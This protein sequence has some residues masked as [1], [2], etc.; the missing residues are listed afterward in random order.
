MNIPFY[1]S[2]KRSF[3]I[4]ESPRDFSRVRPNLSPYRFFLFVVERI[5]G[6]REGRTTVIKDA[7]APAWSY[8]EQRWRSGVEPRES[9]TCRKFLMLTTKPGG[10]PT[11]THWHDTLSWLYDVRKTKKER[12]WKKKTF[13]AFSASSLFILNKSDLGCLNVG[14]RKENCGIR[15]GERYVLLVIVVIRRRNGKTHTRGQDDQS[16]CFF[17]FSSLFRSTKPIFFFLFTS[18][19]SKNAKRYMLFMELKNG[20][21][22]FLNVQSSRCYNV[23]IILCYIY[24]YIVR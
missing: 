23:K 20:W 2:C 7:I 3:S 5:E 8:S 17:F 6:I 22:V 16:I 24:I 19:T 21:R 4:N 1:V 15:M 14:K 13:F 9:L 11:C 18:I 12:N 10:H